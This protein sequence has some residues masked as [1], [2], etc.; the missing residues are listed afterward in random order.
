[1]T[2]VAQTGLPKLYAP[3]TTGTLGGP[4]RFTA[5]LSAAAAWTV[6]VTDATKLV[7][8]SGSGTG[9]TVDW[10]WNSAGAAPGLYTWTISAPQLR[11]ATGTVGA[12]LGPLSL[13]QLKLAP[14]W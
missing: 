8:A 1:M 11:S 6:T 12:A 4:V 14:A 13:Q 7:V 2:A 9:T 10:S 3:V 5:R